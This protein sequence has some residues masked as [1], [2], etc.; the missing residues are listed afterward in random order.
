MKTQ[1][2]E[3]A[4]NRVRLEIEVPAHDVDHAF[5]HALSDLSASVRVPGFRKGKAPA[6]MIARQVG[7]EALVEEALRDHLTG[8]YSRAVAE[9]GIDPID[10][11]TI[12]WS[13]EPVEG[14]PFSFT[15]EVDVKPPPEVA[16]YKGLEGVRQ[17]AD[18]PVE[19]IDGEIERLRLTVAELNPVERPAAAGDFVVIDY[20]GTIDGKPFDDSSGSDYGVQLGE[21]RLVEE[22]ENGIIGMSAGDEQLIEIVIPGEAGQQ[23]TASFRVALKDVKERVLPPLDDDLAT[24]VSEFDTLDEL[25]ADL[26]SNLQEGLNQRSDD[27]F[28]TSVLDALARELTTQA[29]DALVQAR[30]RQTVRGLVNDLQQ[31]GIELEDY[32]RITGQNGEQMLAMITSQAEDTVRKDLALEAV[33]DAEK[34]EISDEMVEEW[35]R[36]QSSEGDESADEAIERLTGDPAVLTALRTDLRMQKA[37]D[38]VV[39]AATE[40]TPEQASAREQLWTPEKDSPAQGEKPTEIWTPGSPQPADR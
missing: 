26:T 39:S 31:R 9:I 29:P 17:P 35:I 18:V 12:D 10:R 6:A 22:L 23:Q 33:A 14:E 5:E 40:I 4:D 13:D 27:L 2:S 24:S 8:W 34:I 16:K 21:G 36:E 25:R 1:V 11:P 3:L 20:E 30:A 7:R 38:I 32:L 28:R 15:A 19:A 37:L